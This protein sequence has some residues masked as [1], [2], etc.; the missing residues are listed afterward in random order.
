MQS[1]QP[2]FMPP[3][4]GLPRGRLPEEIRSPEVDSHIVL[5]SPYH[6]VDSDLV[7]GDYASPYPEQPPLEG[8]VIGQY[9]NSRKWTVRPPPAE[10]QEDVRP[11]PAQPQEDVQLPEDK[12]ILPSNNPPSPR[13]DHARLEE[14]RQSGL[15]TATRMPVLNIAPQ[16]QEQDV[17]SSPKRKVIKMRPLGLDNEDSTPSSPRSAGTQAPPLDIVQPIPSLA[18]VNVTARKK[19]DEPG[20]SSS[21]QPV[22]SLGELP[23]LRAIKVSSPSRT[24][25]PSQEASSLSPTVNPPSSPV[26]SPT[27]ERASADGAVESRTPASIETLSSRRSTDPGSSRKSITFTD[28]TDEGLREDLAAL[29]KAG[30][31]KSPDWERVK[32]RL[33]RPGP[34]LS[35]PTKP[36]E[37]APPP[38]PRIEEEP[39]PTKEEARPP[40]PRIEEE[41]ESAKAQE[42]KPVEPA[43]REKAQEVKP[44]EPVFT[45]ETEE[46]KPVEP[47]FTGE[48]QGMQPTQFASTAGDIAFKRTRIYGSEQFRR[49]KDSAEDFLA[50]IDGVTVTQ[51]PTEA[52][53]CP[54]ATRRLPSEDAGSLDRV[55]HPAYRN[56]SEDS[57]PY[58]DLESGSESEGTALET[59]RELLMEELHGLYRVAS[60]KSTQHA[61]AV[62]S[63]YIETPQQS[64]EAATKWAI[65]ALD[66]S[67]VRM[68]EVREMIRDVRRKM[69][70]ESKRVVSQGTKPKT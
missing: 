18:T 53:D 62:A 24:L 47:A 3:F 23:G 56:S 50:H 10:P 11:P 19:Q 65:P 25:V 20:S 39:E 32:D 69:L 55:A 37:K 51:S 45:W 64:F 15:G 43:S 59:A 61:A 44:T 16:N 49:R 5:L 6:A 35:S 7:S 38:T 70:N 40:T 34:I 27:R 31:P 33:S 9:P 46:T 1:P 17:E 48:A 14:L 4:L 66:T 12:P 68:T 67:P 41:P 26:R 30:T 42:M 52:H 58:M 60:D 13:T 36:K 29:E 63:K 21:G 2:N 22:L 57:Q 54:P 28:L 8:A